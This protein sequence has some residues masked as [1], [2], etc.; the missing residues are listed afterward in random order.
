MQP[1]TLNRKGTAGEPSYGLGL[2]IVYQIVKA[3]KGLIWFNS[4]E[5]KGTSFYIE[6][7]TAGGEA[8]NN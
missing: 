6:F 3:H 8:I 1:G 2:S 5:G 7:P 4:E